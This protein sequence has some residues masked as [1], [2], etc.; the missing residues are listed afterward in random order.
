MTMTENP[1]GYT[2]LGE[3]KR[4]RALNLDP[5]FRER[6]MADASTKKAS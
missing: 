5:P 6:V 3:Q 1:T 4:E 2:D